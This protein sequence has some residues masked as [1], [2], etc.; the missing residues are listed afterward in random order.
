M[1]DVC[2]FIF[3]YFVFYFVFLRHVFN[4]LYLEYN[5]VINNNNYQSFP[6]RL[7]VQALVIYIDIYVSYYMCLILY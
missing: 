3:C 5:S 6:V 4:F 1:S 7:I 2:Q